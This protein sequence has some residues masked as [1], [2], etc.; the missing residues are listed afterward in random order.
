[1]QWTQQQGEAIKAALAWYRGGTKTK[2][3]FRLFGFA[4]TGKTTIAKHIADEIGIDDVQPCAF[5]GKAALV[6][7]KKGLP[8]STLHSLLYKA[9]QDEDTGEVHY[10]LNPDSILAGKRLLLPDEVSMVGED[11]ALDALSFGTKVLVLGDPFQLPP[12]KGQG[13]FTEAEPDVMLTDI[14]RQALDNPITRMSL[15]VREGRGLQPGDYGQ[16]F[17]R[18]RRDTDPDQLAAV[19]LKADQ[20]LCGLNKTRQAMNARMRQLRGITDVMPTP[21]EKL[22]CLKNNKDK[23]FLNGGMWVAKRSNRDEA[24]M[25]LRLD[26]MDI[27]GVTADARVR[28]EFF[29]GT[30]GE[31]HWKERKLSDEF[32]F[33]NA[34]TVHKSQGSEWESVILFDESETFR[35]VAPRHLYTGLT[36]ASERVGIIL[37]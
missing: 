18:R 28:R 8:A 10:K 30:E 33:G 3:V 21:G 1:M 22:I 32:T 37:P 6:L 12:V 35:E 4:G 7:T 29:R 20:V 27:E 14:R 13:Y 31:L 2:Q 25:S 5:T 23:G 15:D 24:Y 9:V 17:V 34:I 26:S 11:L 36:R 16:S 19:V